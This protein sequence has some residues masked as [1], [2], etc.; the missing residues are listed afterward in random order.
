M[1]TV[2]EPDVEEYNVET[3]DDSEEGPAFEPDLLSFFG[4]DKIKEKPMP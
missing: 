4:D 2:D 1:E 3:P